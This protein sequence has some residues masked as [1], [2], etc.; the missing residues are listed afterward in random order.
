MRLS[1]AKNR[2]SDMN[3]HTPVRACFT[4][5]CAAQLVL[6]Q[7]R[8]TPSEEP[9]VQVE[10]V[11][12][13]EQGIQV[14]AGPSQQLIPLELVSAYRIRNGMVELRLNQGTILVTSVG[15]EEFGTG[16]G[17]GQWQ[18]LADRN[19]KR[20]YQLLRTYDR[21]TGKATVATR[22]TRLITTNQ[23]PFGSADSITFDF[24]YAS[25]AD[26]KRDAERDSYES[27]H[28]SVKGPYAPA[29]WPTQQELGRF[30]YPA[31]DLLLLVDG[32]RESLDATFFSLN[33]T[34][35]CH[36]PIDVCKAIASAKVVDGSLMGTEFR[37]TPAQ[38]AELQ[39][40]VA[41]VESL[42]P[43]S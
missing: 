26:G 29:D 11:S 37:F 2:L 19:D 25:T 24:T 32:K 39:E 42:G 31:S 22:E 21:Y 4:V 17:D 40:L 1:F 35:S 10:V 6:A 33:R 9:H 13:D 15:A 18:Q 5:L 30:S 28:I 36:A 7:T 34:W 14:K 41:Y 38:F 43:E 20:R 23:G 12:F 8:E 16:A 27:I 3:F